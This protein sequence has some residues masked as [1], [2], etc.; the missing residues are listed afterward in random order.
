MS[1]MMV[2]VSMMPRLVT[3]CFVALY[4]LWIVIVF[5]ACVVC[6]L[7]SLAEPLQF[8]SAA[9][10]LCRAFSIISLSRPAHCH[11]VGLCRCKFQQS[12]TSVTNLTCFFTFFFL[13]V[14]GLVS[15]SCCVDFSFSLQIECQFISNC[16]SRDF[17]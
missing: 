14:E 3:V 11:L 1:A 2:M 17:H 13:S 5:N 10:L 12:T 4:L 8:T 9:R 7:G 16:P 6:D 15:P